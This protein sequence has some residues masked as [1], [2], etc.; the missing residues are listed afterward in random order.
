MQ[1]TKLT[2]RE[3]ILHFL[4]LHKVEL[5]E[6]LQL[7]QLGLFGS[8]ARDEATAKSDIDLLVEFAPNT[9]DLFEKKQYLRELLFQEFGRKVDVCTIK[10]VKPYFRD[11]IL[12]PAVYV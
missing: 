2:T 6:Q 1:E 5:M 9:P 12:K 8:F 3:D 10:Y 4:R 7:T 11:L